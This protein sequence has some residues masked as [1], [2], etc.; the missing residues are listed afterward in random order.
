MTFAYSETALQHS[1]RAGQLV[2][3]DVAAH[4]HLYAAGQGLEDT[5]YLMVFV[6]ALGTYV[7]VHAGAVAQALEEVEEH[8]GRFIW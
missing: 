2:V 6:G 5:L 8:F 7:E 4:S 1:L 3:M